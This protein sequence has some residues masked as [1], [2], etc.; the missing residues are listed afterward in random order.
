MSSLQVL[1]A[2]HR[3]YLFPQNCEWMRPI[4]IDRLSER[5]APDRKPHFLFDDVGDNISK[6]KPH[7]DELSALYWGWKNLSGDYFGLYQYRRYL[8]FHPQT[9]SNHVSRK[10]NSANIS[11]LSSDLQHERILEILQICDIVVPYGFTM[12]TSIKEQYRLEEH[13]MLAWELMNEAIQIYCPEV[14]PYMSWFE[15]SNTAHFSSVMICGRSVLNEY[16][17]TLFNILDY[18]TER[19]GVLPDVI[20]Q[21]YQPTR[22][23]SYLAERFLNVWILSKRLRKFEAQWVWVLE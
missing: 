8:N 2:T 6:R 19:L 17:A 22:Y 12:E 21:R 4:G 9:T 14:V 5:L 1:I 7:F 10:A 16:C 13:S 11:Y 3:D 15:L 23:P 18:L 20:G